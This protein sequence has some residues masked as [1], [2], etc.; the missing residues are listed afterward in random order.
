MERRSF[1][2]GI[3]VAALSRRAGIAEEDVSRVYDVRQFGATGDGRSDDTIAIRRALAELNKAGGVLGARSPASGSAGLLRG[4]TSS[5]A[6]MAT[7]GRPS[8][9]A[10]K[11]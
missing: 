6:T 5:A 2:G 1:L 3:T 11:T 10:S 9:A 4:A 8:V 7:P